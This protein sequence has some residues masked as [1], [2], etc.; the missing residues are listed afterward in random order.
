MPN[1]L[2]DVRYALR[3]LRKSPGFAVT[4]V[5]TLALGIGAN[6][7]VFSVLNSLLLQPLHFSHPERVVFV[8]A[9]G[10]VYGV[11]SYPDYRD[12][13]DR[14]STFS[15]LA[16][17]R[18]EQAGLG[19][20]KGAQPVWGLT[21]SGNYFGT[22]EVRPYLGRMLQP[23]DDVHPGASPYV[24]LSYDCWR[25]LFGGDKG[26]IGRTVQLDKFPYTVVGVAP[27]SFSGTERWFAP[28]FWV[29]VMNQAQL[30]GGNWLESRGNSNLWIFG[31]LRPR[32]SAAAAAANVDALAHELAKQYPQ[33]DGGT[34]Y[35]LT[36]PGLMGDV[37]GGPA[38]AFLGGVMLLGALVL[39]AACANLGSLFAARVSD[40]GR[41]LA[42]RVAVGASRG[43]ILRQLLAESAVVSLL[44]GA[45][46]MGLALLLLGALNRW[47]PGSDFGGQIVIHPDAWVYVFAIAVSFATGM[48]FGA[49]PARQVWRT[50][51]GDAIK[52]GSRISSGPGWSLR[53]V[54][55]VVQ[56]AICSLLVTASLV[57]ARGLA[58]TLHANLGIRPANVT[59]AHLDLKLDGFSSEGAEPVQRRLLRAVLNLPG[60]NAAAYANSVPLSVNQSFTG[61]YAADSPDFT[62]RNQ[63]FIAT[64]YKVSPGYFSAAG[65]RLLAGRDFTWQDGP[66]SP[67]FVIVNRTFARQLFG[68]A[69][70]VGRRV[71]VGGQN[72]EEIVGVVEDGKYTTIAESPRAVVFYPIL[73]NTDPNTVLLVRSA[74]G[75]PAMVAQVR[76]A[77]GRVDRSL[78][79]SFVGSWRE[80]LS[81]ALLPAYA[82][83]AALGAFGALAMML[84][85]TGIFGL[86]AFTVSRRM[87]ELGIR[88]A[89]G[90]SRGQLVGAALRRP[91]ILLAMG[92]MAGLVA[93]IAGS[94]VLASIV[95]QATSND[96][97]VLAGVVLAMVLVGALA[98]WIPARRVLAIDP[99]DVLRES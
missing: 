30:D 4:A 24:V 22:L 55:L 95:Y 19:T 25:N 93:G 47:S 26:I 99:I 85:L 81:T 37:M 50:D 86:A 77:I 1:L 8:Q 32:V 40:R 10:N 2:F 21:V 60:V 42:V 64:Y 97:L 94:R 52:S 39:L 44:G 68:T 34:S 36:R 76:D 78:P 48:I 12:L 73:E 46:G 88:V 3:R 74:G 5:L 6:V 89:L 58:R 13:R 45:V 15:S 71:N 84:A 27:R 63:K 33:T 18:I 91:V 70:A 83:T 56:I 98:T 90:A 61:I 14:N 51:P 49:M 57:A 75:G 43:R 20:A 53:D 23:A 79:V 62:S 66:K 11:S 59:L 54:L 31:R 35:R 69:D 92:S 87:R 29:P 41:E 16:M 38:R 82:A 65:T 96:P 9:T 80:E 72:L 67:K 7:V 17:F 28:Q